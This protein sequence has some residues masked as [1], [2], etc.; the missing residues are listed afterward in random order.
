[1]AALKDIG[2]L[3]TV[4]AH[5]CSG[6]KAHK[7]LLASD[8]ISFVELRGCDKLQVPHLQ[9]PQV[10]QLDLSSLKALQ[11]LD[12]FLPKLTLLDLSS[13]PS[14]RSIDDRLFQSCP[15][16]KELDVRDCPR[17]EVITGITHAPQ[18]AVIRAGRCQRLVSLGTDEASELKQGN[19]RAFHAVRFLDL[20]G[21]EMLPVQEIW[22]FFANTWGGQWSAD[23]TAASCSWWQQCSFSPTE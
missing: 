8:S 11:G 18:L 7:P 22:A 17:L 4:I 9:L 20:Y 15:A 1:M 10:E 21:C 23:Q 5:E 13:C 12:G 14:L 6:F 16:L 3:Q 2:N 19:G